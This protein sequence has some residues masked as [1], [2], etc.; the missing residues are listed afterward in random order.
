MLSDKAALRTSSMGAGDYHGVDA[1]R[2]HGLDYI[3]DRL[4]ML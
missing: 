1:A 3:W 2:Y 4:K